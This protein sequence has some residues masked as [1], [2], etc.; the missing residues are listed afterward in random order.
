MDY[1]N[2]RLEQDMSNLNKAP[3]TTVFFIL[4]VVF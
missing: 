1:V 2:E 4:G 3:N